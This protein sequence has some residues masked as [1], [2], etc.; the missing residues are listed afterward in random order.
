MGNHKITDNGF[1]LL[2]EQLSLNS[3]VA[4]LYYNYYNSRDE[5]VGFISKQKEQLQCVISSEDIPFGQSQSPL[6]SEYADGVDTL[7][8]LQSI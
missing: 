4:V 6:I 2:K 1:I 7:D 3:P 5:V 8:F